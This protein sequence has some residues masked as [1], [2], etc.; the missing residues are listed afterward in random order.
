MVCCGD[1]AGAEARARRCGQS[2][3]HESESRVNFGLACS[4]NCLVPSLG[5]RCVELMGYED[6]H[7]QSIGF[8]EKSFFD[9]EADSF[10]PFS[11]LYFQIQYLESGDIL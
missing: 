11:V 6:G 7:S 9:M 8:A 1:G 3:W 4:L 10:P 5:R 2:C